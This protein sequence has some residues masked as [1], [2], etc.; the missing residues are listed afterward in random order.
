M[1]KKRYKGDE[2]DERPT[3]KQIKKALAN[4]E[5]SKKMIKGTATMEHLN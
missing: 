1:P 5:Y 2:E 4:Y 3:E